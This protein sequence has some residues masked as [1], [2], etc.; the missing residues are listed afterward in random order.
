MKTMQDRLDADEASVPPMTEDEVYVFPL[1]FAQ[2][3]LWVLDRLE[4]N[5]S[6]YNLPIPLRVKGILN[7]EAL[8]DSLTAILRRHEVL[9]STFGE[10]D[11]TPVQIVPVSAAASLA[12]TD[13]SDLPVEQREANAREIAKEDARKPFDLSR[14]P[15][16]LSS[17]VTFS[18][19][20][21]V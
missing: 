13:L 2:Q 21:H 6:V 14:G 18:S 12:F 20:H 4:P 15:V 1:S 17:L 9:H 19:P 7:V 10:Q 11:G 3:R 16:F 8:R 5:S